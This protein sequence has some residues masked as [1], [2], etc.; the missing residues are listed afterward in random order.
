MNLPIQEMNGLKFYYRPDTTDEKVIV[1]VVKRH[2]YTNK[3]A[4][5]ISSTD[6]WLD[7]GGNIGTFTCLAASQGC[8]VRTY[9]PEPECFEIL[10]A[11]VSL[12]GL[13]GL[14]E[15]HQRAVTAKGTP[16]N[17]Y[18]SKG[19]NKY[20]HTIFEVRGRES[21]IVDATA[22]EH[23]MNLDNFTAVKMDIEGAELEIFDSADDWK[24]VIKLAFE[25]H[26]DFDRSIAA[27]NN[28]MNKLKDSFSVVRYPKMPTGKETY[29][30]FPSGKTVHCAKIL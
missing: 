18:L 8:R 3:N 19:Q 28:R 10:K 9:E 26:F 23:V 4:F 7:L 25:Y 30:F 11:N 6:Y 5:E 27:F 12:N 2:N 15:L 22:F 13:E 17:L 14:V 24:D 1:E 16:V 21:V 20:R 29:D